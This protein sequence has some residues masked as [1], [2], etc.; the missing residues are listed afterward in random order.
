MRLRLSILFAILASAATHAAVDQNAK[1]EILLDDA[2]ATLLVEKISDDLTSQRY[3]AALQ[4]AKEAMALRPNDAIVLN[5]MGA[6]LTETKRYD[7]ASKILDAAIAADPKGVPQKF[8]RGE[9]LF[10][11]KKYADAAEY[12]ELLQ[13]ESTALSILKYK[14]FLCYA[15]AGNKDKADAALALMRYPQDGPAWYFAYGVDRLLAG[16]KDEGRRL[17][18]TAQ[19]ID[20]KDAAIYVESLRDTGLLK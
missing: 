4:K 19:A 7:E 12:F 20:A 15:L 3:E 2:R 16:K 11:Q 1:F 17:I 10:L 13:I 14:I 5:A 18:A 9:L 8:N 6:V